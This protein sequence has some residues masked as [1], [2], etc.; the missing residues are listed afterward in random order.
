MCSKANRSQSFD[1]M[2]PYPDLCPFKKDKWYSLG[3]LRR[4]AAEI[5]DAR[6]ADSNLSAMM[7]VNTSAK[8]WNEETS[9]KSWNEELRPLKVLADNKQW[10]DDVEFCWTPDGAADFAVRVARSDT[11]KIQVT[12]AYPEW[13]DSVGEHGGHVNALEMGAYNKNGLAYP[14]GLVNK[15]RAR[16]VYDDVEACRRG[17]V[18]ALQNKVRPEYAGCHLLIFAPRFGFHTIDFEF[19]QVVAPAIEQ[20][21]WACVFEALYVCDDYSFFEAKKACP[22]VRDDEVD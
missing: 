13:P 17:I 1:T 22:A 16:G 15:P 5:Q 18:K 6:Q 10:S 14:G 20:M 2:I 12:M 3:E 11:I 7:R 19:A 9:A 8:L 21:E 4:A